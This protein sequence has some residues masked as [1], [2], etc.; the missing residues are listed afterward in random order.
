MKQP[1]TESTQR[2][3][4]VA[5]D[6]SAHSQPALLFGSK[7]ARCTQSPLLILH[8][9]H[10]SG[11]ET[12]N[13]R[14]HDTS[15]RLLPIDQVAKHML[16]DFILDLRARHAD[17]TA[18]EG[19]RPLLVMGIPAQRIAEVAAQQDAIMIIMGSHGRSGLSHL[20]MGSVAEQVTRLSHLPV[21]I[22]KDG[23]AGRESVAAFQANE[24]FKVPNDSLKVPNDALKIPDI[25]WQKADPETLREA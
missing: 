23:E 11:A 13:Y 7:L 3:I 25:G 2:P 15:R 1:P 20:L 16:Q 22:I 24:T 19:A 21:T 6:F 4:L 10:E 12:G 9:I 17:T 18:L 8:V 14:K 5:V